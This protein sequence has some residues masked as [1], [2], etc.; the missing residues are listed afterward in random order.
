M[1]LSMTASQEE[2]RVSTEARDELLKNQAFPFRTHDQSAGLSKE[3][4]FLDSYSIFLKLRF[5]LSCVIAS[6]TFGLVL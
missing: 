1:T 6:G 3:R 4:R 5:N 2:T